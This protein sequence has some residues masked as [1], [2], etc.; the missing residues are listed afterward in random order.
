[1]LNMHGENRDCH[2]PKGQ[3]LVTHP[4]LK[5]QMVHWEPSLPICSACKPLEP[6]LC[7][8]ALKSLWHI[9]KEYILCLAYLLRS[10]TQNAAV[11]PTAKYQLVRFFSHARNRSLVCEPFSRYICILYRSFGRN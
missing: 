7:L 1:M 4:L 11:C 2:Y 5:A 10:R 6:K 8:E 9:P 3:N